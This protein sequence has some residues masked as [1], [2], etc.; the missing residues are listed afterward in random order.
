MRF[1]WRNT[2]GAIRRPAGRERA[3]RPPADRLRAR[4]RHARDAVE[5]RFARALQ[6]GPDVKWDALGGDPW[7]RH[8]GPETCDDLA[9]PPL[10][11]HHRAVHAIA[12]LTAVLCAAEP[13]HLAQL[14]HQARRI[15]DGGRRVTRK[16]LLE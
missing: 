13:L 5:N 2:A 16:R 11:R 1:A 15:A 9:G 4:A 14:V 7:G 12:E 8:R 10:E 6:G 3:G